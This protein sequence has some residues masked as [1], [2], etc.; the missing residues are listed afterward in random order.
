MSATD[1]TLDEQ[2]AHLTRALNNTNS[3]ASA[4]GIS[5][6]AASACW[7]NLRGAGVFESDRAKMVV[8]VLLEHITS[9]TPATP[10]HAEFAAEVN[11]LR[12]QAHAQ[13][14]AELTAQRDQAR[15]DYRR[16]EAHADGLARK[17]RWFEHQLNQIRAFVAPPAPED[18][19]DTEVENLEFRPWNPDRR[20]DPDELAGAMRPRPRLVPLEQ[21]RDRVDGLIADRTP[22]PRRGPTPARPTPCPHGNPL[23]IECT[24]GC[25][26]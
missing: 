1:A 15:E 12:D 25:R 14:V 17:V 20:P 26:P 11:R 8:D 16:A 5:V 13:Q 21:L 2:R 4:I 24:D 10:G 7:S 6:G 19:Q 3:L 23:A 9:R 18:D 22:G